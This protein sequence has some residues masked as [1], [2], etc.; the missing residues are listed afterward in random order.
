MD[1]KAF[2]DK[3]VK[4][5]NDLISSALGNTMVY[6]KDLMEYISGHFN[7][8]TLEWRFYTD[9]KSWLLPVAV[10][11]K[12]LAWIVVYEGYF[13]V[14]FWFGNKLDGIVE[15]SGLPEKVLEEYRRAK[16]SKMGRGILITVISKTDLDHVKQLLEFKSN[17][18]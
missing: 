10:K 9:A 13:R 3:T 7:E 17:I 2:T 4:P 12:N 1:V 14:S 5:D 16:Q 6:W 18:K 8:I 15:K 11:K